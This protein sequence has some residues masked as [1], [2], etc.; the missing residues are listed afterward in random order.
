MSIEC[1]ED[2]EGLAQAGQ[3]VAATLKAMAGAVRAGVT[4]AEVD[5]VGES[6]LNRYGATSAPR[7]FYGFPG[8]NLIS[9]NDEII[10]GIPSDRVLE[11]GDIVSLDVTAELNGYIADAAITIPIPPYSAKAARLCRCVRTAFEKAVAVARANKPINC[12]GHAVEHEVKRQGFWVVNELAGH[13]VGR[14]IHEDPIVANTY[15]PFDSKPLTNGLVITIE[16]MIAEHPTQAVEDCDGWTV[17]TS[18]GSLSA[19]FEHTVVITDG[20]P[21]LL[22][23]A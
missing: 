11:Q 20:Q 4:T 12:I 22:T 23:A 13:G 7:L 14:V 6:V 9:V 17:K 3:V 21:I 10:H 18:N 15:N 2:F 5:R 8:V 1:P 16:P 19:H